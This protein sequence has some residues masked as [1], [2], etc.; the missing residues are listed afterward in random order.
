MGGDA[1]KACVSPSCE[2]RLLEWVEEW[3]PRDVLLI[4]GWEAF[5]ARLPG[6]VKVERMSSLPCEFPCLG[7]VYDL[8]LLALH[9]LESSRNGLDPDSLYPL[10]A[11]LR[12]CH[13]RELLLVVLDT[14]L[15]PRAVRHGE[16]LGLGLRM[17]A[18]WRAGDGAYLRCYRYSRR[19][20]RPMPRWLNSQ[21][22]AHPARFGQARW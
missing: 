19:A 11:R 6:T 1:S 7:R 5:T 9:S 22:W 4:G 8:V 15:R 12:D 3:G 18:R 14:A 2:D 21:H 16:L 10:L 17:E 13:A 20:A